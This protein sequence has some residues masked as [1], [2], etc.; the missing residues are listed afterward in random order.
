MSA[1]YG[2]ENNIATFTI[3]PK[4]MKSALNEKK[5]QGFWEDK[6]VRV[7]PSMQI[8]IEGDWEADNIIA[9]RTY[10]NREQAFKFKVPEFEY[11]ETENSIELVANYKS[12]KILAKQCFIMQ[13]GINCITT[14]C[15]VENVGCEDVVLESVPSFNISRILSFSFLFVE[16]PTILTFLISSLLTGIRLFLIEYVPFSANLQSVFSAYSKALL[17]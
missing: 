17:S 2:I 1:V 10:R 9:G 6:G 15:E 7:E 11:S 8:G 12:E 13:K 5:M 14:F 16:T 3:I 4:D